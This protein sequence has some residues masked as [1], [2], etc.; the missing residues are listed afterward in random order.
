MSYIRKT[1]I[2]NGLPDHIINQILSC[3]VAPLKGKFENEPSP[4][5]GERRGDHVIIKT[6]E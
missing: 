6:Y 3:S 5:K 4:P 2:K 1:L